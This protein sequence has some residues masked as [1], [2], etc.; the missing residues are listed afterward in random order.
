MNTKDRNEVIRAIYKLFADHSTLN[1]QYGDNNYA[2]VFDRELMLHSAKIVIAMYDIGG[3]N[4]RIQF[5]GES[6][7]LQNETLPNLNIILEHL[8]DTYADDNEPLTE[9]DYSFQLGSNFGAIYGLPFGGTI[10]AYNRKDALTEVQKLAK[11]TAEALLTDF[12]EQNN[13]PRNHNLH[14]VAIAPI[15]TS[16]SVTET[17]LIDNVADTHYAEIRDAINRAWATIG[18]RGKF[19]R[20][21]QPYFE[22]DKREMANRYSEECVWW[23]LSENDFAYALNKVGLGEIVYEWCNFIAD[24]EDLLAILNY[25]RPKWWV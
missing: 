8:T 23:E 4:L 11:K 10:K 5:K 15:D 13:T 24:D 3:G 17:K 16:F 18:Y 21:I 25:I 20:I 22:R 1:A 7:P 19:E 14:I 9:F 2:I 6:E 12:N